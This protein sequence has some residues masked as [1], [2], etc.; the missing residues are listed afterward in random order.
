MTEIVTARIS[1]LDELQ[2]KLNTLPAELSRRALKK[3]LRPAGLIFRNEM[4]Q[5]GARLTGWM[6]RNIIVRVK[7]NN[8][9][10]GSVKVSFS[11]KQNPARI[12]KEKHVP[13]AVQE[14]LWNEFGTSKMHAK[15]FIRPAFEHKKD[16]VVRTFAESLSDALSEVFK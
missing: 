9:D 14:A 1:G 15:P 3:G 2:R 10:Q 5:L 6:L 4:Q 8:L 12:G 11:R 13:S 16:E 7:T